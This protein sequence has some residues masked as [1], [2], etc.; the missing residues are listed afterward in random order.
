MYKQNGTKIFRQIGNL[1]LAIW[2]LFFL[3][4][5]IAVGTIIEQG[6]SLNFYKETYSKSNIIKR[7]FL[8]I[9]FFGL[10]RI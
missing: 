2:L 7:F 6:Q 8:I 1:K 3:G 9:I 4:I 10:D 5:M